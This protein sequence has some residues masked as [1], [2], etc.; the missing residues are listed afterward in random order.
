MNKAKV[1]CLQKAYEDLSLR[2][3]T[4][5]DKKIQNLLEGQAYA[6][7]RA[8][9]TRAV[10]A[11]LSSY[12]NETTQSILDIGAGTGAGY[13]AFGIYNVSW[14]LVEPNE[15]MHKNNKNNH[16]CHWYATIHEAPSCD[17]VLLSYVLN[18]ILLND[19][20]AFLI[21]TWNKVKDTLIITLPGTPDDYHL[22]M[23]VRTYL[24][25]LGAIL[26]A[27]C[28]HIKACPLP[29]DD[30]CHFS[31]RLPRTTE[32]Q[33]IK[34]G[35]KGFEDEKYCY[36]VFKKHAIP[37]SASRIIKPPRLRKGHCYFDVCH[38]KGDIKTVVVSRK[39]EIY[40]QCRHKDWGDTLLM[41]D[42][43]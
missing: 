40:K 29:A 16:H 21:S 11:S 32:H 20:H 39:N 3:R 42:I 6:K 34:Q 8:P 22:L 9:A 10:L 18:E 19:L 23:N 30:W 41:S 17:V 31:A 12:V 7:A 37:S 5:K 4:R 33:F 27:P 26:M 2:Y 24:L 14:H 35:K 38:A 25:K 28:P 13:E 15:A 36:L 43:V 1:P